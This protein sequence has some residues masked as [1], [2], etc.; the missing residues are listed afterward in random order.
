MTN[1]KSILDAPIK[2]LNKSPMQFEF[3]HDAIVHDSR[4]FQKHDHDLCLLTKDNPHLDLSCGNEFRP[5]SILAP[6]L[7]HHSSW[8]KIENYLTHC[9]S[10]DFKDT[11]E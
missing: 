11:D 8:S 3:N 9:F 2:N 6:L 4:V 10:A 1:T 5:V 7:H